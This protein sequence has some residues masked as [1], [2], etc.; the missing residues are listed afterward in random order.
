MLVTNKYT[1]LVIGLKPPQQLNLT[2][3]KEGTNMFNDD[4][5]PSPQRVINLLTPSHSHTQKILEPSAGKGDLA[6]GIK[7][8]C[9]GC[10]IDVIELDTKLCS[11]LTDSGFNLVGYDFLSYTTNTEYTAIVMNPPF[12]EGAKHLIKAIELAEKQVVHSCQIKA[13]VNAETIKNL[14][15]KE[16]QYLHTLLTKY[17]ASIDYY[18][19]LFSSAERK[20]DV[21]CAIITMTV[22]CTH[23]S[24]KSIYQD[25]IDN[26]TAQ[27]RD[28]IEIEKSLSTLLSGQELQERIYDIATLVKQYEFHVSLVKDM[29]KSLESIHYLEKLIYSENHK[30]MSS[31]IRMESNL[32]DC[33]DTLRSNYWSAI[34]QT[35]QF[36]KNLTSYGSSQINKYLENI[37]TMEITINNI[38]LL[39]Q[40]LYQNSSNILLDACIHQFEELTKYHNSTFSKNIHY[41]NGWDTNNA[42]KLN[43]KIIVPIS[44]DP[45]YRLSN[46][47][48]DLSYDLKHFLEDFSKMFTWFNPTFNT[49]FTNIDQYEFENDIFR[50]KIFLKGTIHIWFKDL[51]LLEQFNYTCGKAKNWLPTSDEIKN[52]KEA[53]LF[54]AKE[55]PHYEKIKQLNNLI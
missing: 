42:Y 6:E 54:I 34:L 3:Q 53:Q 1:N 18:S 10:S 17:N 52:N 25:I 47:F 29:F 55:F 24:I 51:F 19:N 7:K 8:D 49:T 37:S 40:A 4:F 22:N 5:Y 39:L 2:I 38:E 15:T 33:L 41:Y 14:H 46:Q 20:T 11:I 13:I 32:N 44:R 50:F 9:R 16:R 35:D 45:F 43:K 28:T 12:S 27:Q 48:E 23:K 26:V 30:G 21:E 31:Y 36:R